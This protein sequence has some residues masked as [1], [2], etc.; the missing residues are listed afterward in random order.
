MKK[1]VVF[2]FVLTL[3]VSAGD[4][5][6]PEKEKSVVEYTEDERAVEDYNEAR[7]FGR[8]VSILG[9]TVSTLGM[10]VVS[11]Y[12]EWSGMELSLLGVAIA[13]FGCY[14]LFKNR[15]Q[16]QKINEYQ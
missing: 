9:A 10:T 16:F 13:G 15:K 14:V 6:V 3:P 1:L 8:N 7:S 11:Q 2:L 12:D 5:P 4:E